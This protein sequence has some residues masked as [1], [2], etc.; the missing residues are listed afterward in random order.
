MDNSFSP[1]RLGEAARQTLDL[2]ANERN[3]KDGAF[4][5][6]VTAGT[7]PIEACDIILSPPLLAAEERDVY[8]DF[9]HALVYIRDHKLK[10]SKMLMLTLTMKPFGKVPNGHRSRSEA[11]EIVCGSNIDPGDGE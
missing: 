11:S 1:G 4:K 7:P 9:R 5:G 8:H 2:T 6:K 3:Y 10:L